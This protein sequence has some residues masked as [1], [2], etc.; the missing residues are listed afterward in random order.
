VRFR[1]C[2]STLPTL[3]VLAEWLQSRTPRT[4]CR[5][6]PKGILR[7]LCSQ[8]EVDAIAA[9][10]YGLTRNTPNFAKPHEVFAGSMHNVATPFFQ[11]NQRVFDIQL[12]S[13]ILIAGCRCRSSPS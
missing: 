11:E 3:C 2:A 6:F 13:T 12:E 10:A 8:T 9:Q 5:D 4:C 1:A 7:T